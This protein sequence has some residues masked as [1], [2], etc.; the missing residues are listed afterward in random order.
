MER[1][2]VTVKGERVEAGEVT[3]GSSCYEIK[4][5]LFL[6]SAVRHLIMVR[7]AATAITPANKGKL[8]RKG[9]TTDQLLKEIKVRGRAR[10]DMESRAGIHETFL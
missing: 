9:Q 3:L 8:L 10:I 4:S 6:V 7:A 5:L 2:K 1:K